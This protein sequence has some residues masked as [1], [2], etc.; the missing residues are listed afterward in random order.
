[1]AEHA[2]VGAQ[3][4]SIIHFSSDSTLHI[5]RNSTIPNSNLLILTFPLEFFLF[6]EGRGYLPEPFGQKNLLASNFLFQRSLNN[7]YIVTIG[8]FTT[9]KHRKM[10]FSIKGLNH[11]G[12]LE[13]K[14]LP[15][16]P[17]T[18]RLSFE[19]KSHT[20]TSIL[21]REVASCIFSAECTFHAK[22]PFIAK[23]TF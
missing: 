11:G 4:Q 10:I 23:C 14:N 8:W 13:G 22:C 1:M 20:L 19:Q 21:S 5:V 17:W 9:K 18:V 16:K 7:K 2:W 12:I 3:T 15:T 6:P